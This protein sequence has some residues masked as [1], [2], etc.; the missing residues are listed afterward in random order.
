MPKESDFKNIIFDFGGVLMDHNLEGCL[1]AFRRFMS[2]ADI[3]HILGLGNKIPSTLRAKFE[4]KSWN[5][6]QWF[7][8][9]VLSHSRTG[10]TEQQVIDAWNCMHAGISS[11]KWQRI[12]RLR[13]KGNR[14]Y[15]LSNTDKIHWE[16][17][18]ALY[19]DYFEQLFDAIFLSFN[20]EKAK[21]DPSIFKDVDRAIHANPRQTYFVDDS[22]EN[23][24]AA[25][26]SVGW[27]GCADFDELEAMLHT[28]ANLNNQ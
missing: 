22:A 9:Q 21:P 6:P 26:Q 12:K 25:E 17:T 3:E 18:M 20:Y 11:D 15:L 5:C 19:Q 13:S 10:T 28:T 27:I 7:V 24:V 14:I 8:E 16:H 23:R 1:Q 4:T 2:D